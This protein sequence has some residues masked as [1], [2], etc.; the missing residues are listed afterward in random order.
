MSE[1][2]KINR[3]YGLWSSPITP[4]SLAR[5]I[6][7][8]DV[9]WDNSGALLWREGRSDRGVLVIQPPEGQ[10]PRDLN[11]DY[12]VRAKVGYGGGDFCVSAGKVF[13]ADADSGR[14]YLQPLQAGQARPLTPGFGSAAA[15]RLSPDGRWLVYVHTYEGTDTLAIVDAEGALWPSIIATGHDF[16]MQPAW[17]PDSRRLAYIAWDHPNMPWDGTQLIVAKLETAQNGLPCLVEEV[18]LAGSAEVSIFQPEF[19]P[20]GRYLAY[21]SDESGWWQLYL[22]DLQ[23]GTQRQLTYEL[24]EHGQPAWTQ[25]LR[26][27]AFS[28][29][30]QE[31]YFVRNQMGLQSLWRLDLNTG[32]AQSL[33][34][35]GYTSLDQIAVAPEGQ[36]LAFIAS[37]PENPMRIVVFHLNGGVSVQRRSTAEDLP[38]SAYSVP[39]HIAWKGS[40]G[41]EVYGLFYRPHNQ[42]YMANGAPPLI[43][44]IHGGPTSQRTLGFSLSTQFFTSRGYAYLDVN[45]RGSTGYGRAYRNMLR[46]SWG[47]YDV[48]DAVSGA[49]SLAERGL[50]DS[51]R[52]V[53]LG[54]S[55][56]GFTVLKALEDHPGFFKAGICLYGVSNQFT[57]AAETHKFEAHYTDTLVGL[58][59]EASALYRERSPVFFADRIKDPMA[60]FQGEIDVVVPR[61]QSDE[62]VAN[63]RQRGV[64]HIYHLYPG[65]GHGFRKTETIEHYYKTVDKFLHQFVIFS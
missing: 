44:S 23:N 61:A 16:Y 62:V 2:T 58:L 52:M 31:L 42:R 3:P 64:P 50:V 48:E 53:I 27:F 41:G 26:V 8:S 32:K 54:G 37:G 13:F 4:I 60:I 17:H 45:Y 24:A 29:N 11:S 38:P 39:E 43:V 28:P 63:L 19:S 49:R 40:D 18:V 47:I 34:V 36:R 33:P 57:L 21:V 65:E 9:A 14:L 30:N 55:A 22:A 25:G 51:Q 35:D 10:A 5:G 6:S 15:P 1:P 59:P 56:G 20:D 7:F 46:S 12:S